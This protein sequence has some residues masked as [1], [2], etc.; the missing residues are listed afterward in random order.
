MEAAMLE[1]PIA[2]VALFDPVNRGIA[3]PNPVHEELRDGGPIVR[4]RAPMGGWVWIVTDET[5]AREVLTH[6]SIGK[7]TGLAPLE[8]DRYA[9]GLEPS[10]A[11]RA[12]LTTADGPDHLRLRRAHHPAFTARQIA[13]RA[14]QIAATARRLLTDLL[15]DAER[16]VDLMADFTIRF[17]LT[18]VCDLIGVPASEHDRAMAACR[19]MT[20]GVPSDQGLAIAELMDVAST[21]PGQT[22][23]DNVPD[24]AD[25]HYLLFG[26]I[27]AGQLTTD[28]ALGF[29]LAH[30][31][32]GRNDDALVREVLREHPPA[33]FSL[34]RFTTQDV[35]LG[36][37]RL[38]PR[39]PVLVDIAGINAR[40]GDLTFGAGPHYCLG[41]QLAQLE[42]EAAVATLREHFPRARLAVP[43]E[44]L[45][46]RSVGT[47]VG[48]RLA[49][50][51]VT[52]R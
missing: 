3:E 13:A 44:Q 37:V 15:A 20:N 24:G 9:A 29:V 12:S 22:V 1:A 2:D 49:S 43:F 48:G 6:R 39:A 11:E 7:D 38:P 47:T 42:L 36:G 8:W 5:L 4:V 34:W 16:E 25:P 45:R 14:G 40:G 51:P 27:F 35:E 19:R 30:A 17:P 23:V 33:P 21:A 46:Q 41:A 32:N 31:L 50:L 52:L 26:L 10:A 28:A 18:V